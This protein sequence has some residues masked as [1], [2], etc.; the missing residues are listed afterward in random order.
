MSSTYQRITDS[1]VHAIEATGGATL[2]WRKGW[3]VPAPCNYE[4]GRAY[5]GVNRLVLECAHEFKDHRWLTFAQA[6]KL[7]ARVLRGSKSVPI[8]LWKESE[9]DEDNDRRLLCRTYSVFNADQV[10]G[11]PQADY[12]PSQP[13]LLSGLER[14]EEIFNGYKD[15]PPIRHGGNIACYSPS[16]DEIR[17]P[18]P[19]H[20]NSMSDYYSTAFH[21][22]AHSCGSAN[23]LDRVTLRKAGEGHHYRALEELIAELS[24]AFL[25]SEAGIYAESQHV[26]YLQSWLQ[27]FRSDASFIVKAS[28]AS[29]RASDY[30]LGK[31][32]KLDIEGLQ[33][34]R[35]ERKL[36][37]TSAS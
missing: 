20:F 23:R 5:R 22:F 16:R 6:Q 9:A 19:E 3:H 27:C 18:R 28:S 30:I 13:T 7:G 1:I 31:Y 14:A 12:S 17:L 8:I 36:E 10:D 21:E 29:Q 2:P 34:Y 25:C 4:T 24:S 35:E 15:C 32:K 37:L 33:R 26:A 11:L